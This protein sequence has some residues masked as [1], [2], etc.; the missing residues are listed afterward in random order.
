MNEQTNFL[1]AQNLAVQNTNNLTPQT[2][3]DALNIVILAG[4]KSQ[5]MGQDKALVLWQGIPL[6]H[7]V[8]D[9]AM[10][11]VE[12]GVKNVWIMS[13]WCERYKP[14]IPHDDH[15][16]IGYLPESQPTQGPLF[17]LVKA[18][19]QTQSPWILLLACDLPKLKANWLWE[20]VQ[21]AI[22]ELVTGNDFAV[23]S[24]VLPYAVVPRSARYWES[25]CALYHRSCLTSLQTFINQN[26]NSF[27][28][29]LDQ[30]H[31]QNK[32]QV[33]SLTEKQQEYLYNCNTPQD[34]ENFKPM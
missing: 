5:R 28:G 18:F 26:G 16:V 10:I 22:A 6:L 30:L 17:A 29:W 14:F 11:G 8:L 13:P 4:G 33:I 9:V 21:T 7:R 27:Q 19:A 20:W 23:T 12:M 2:S 1:A 25:L 24:D 3:F 34:L 32:I 31:Q 15:N